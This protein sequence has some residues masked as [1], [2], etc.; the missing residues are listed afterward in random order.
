MPWAVGY[1]RLET[2]HLYSISTSGWF[3]YEEVS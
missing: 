2:G 3:L 1:A